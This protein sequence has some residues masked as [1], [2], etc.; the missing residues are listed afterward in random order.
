[1][2]EAEDVGLD[3]LVDAC[4]KIRYR[5]AVIADEMNTKLS[6]LDDKLTKFKQILNEHCA[7]TGAESVRTATGTFYRSVKTK[8]WT[9]DW[10]SMN[11][12]IMEHSAMDLLEKRLHQTNMRTF[13]EE[14]PDKLPP[15]LN[16]DREYT[17][18]VRRKK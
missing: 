2:T 13:L 15:G 3:R 4:V 7:S 11:K 17:I 8:F 12:F 14:N 9:S 16:A 5:K 1:M 18:T 10:E 6:A